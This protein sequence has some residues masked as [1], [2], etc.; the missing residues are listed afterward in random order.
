MHSLPWL[1]PPAPGSPSRS[2][3]LAVLS[4]SPPALAFHGAAPIRPALMLP[5]P[6]APHGPSPDWCPVPARS[7]TRRGDPPACSGPPES[8][9]SG[10]GG[11]GRGRCLS[12]F[13]WLASAEK[14]CRYYLAVTRA[15]QSLG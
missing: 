13:P 14:V 10:S 9:R 5:V 15:C 1:P 8:V 6:A 7:A 3:H 11:R 4:D 12:E 2:T